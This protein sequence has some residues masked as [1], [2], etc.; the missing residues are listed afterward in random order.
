M[1]MA[2]RLY[3]NMELFASACETSCSNVVVTGALKILGTSAIIRSPPPYMTFN[4]LKRIWM[5]QQLDE[6]KDVGAGAGAGAGAGGAPPSHSIAKYMGIIATIV[7]HADEDCAIAPEPVPMLAPASAPAPEPAPAPATATP[8]A[9][10]DQWKSTWGTDQGGGGP[11]HPVLSNISGQRGGGITSDE[12]LCDGRLLRL[13][14][15]LPVEDG[16]RFVRDAVSDESIGPENVANPAPAKIQRT[17]LAFN[18]LKMVMDLTHDFL[19]V[20]PDIIQLLVLPPDSL[21]ETAAVRFARSN[22]R[23]GGLGCQSLSIF[24]PP[25]EK[26]GYRT[27]P[28]DGTQVQAAFGILWLYLYRRWLLGAKEGAYLSSGLKLLYGPPCELETYLRIIKCARADTLYPKAAGPIHKMR[29]RLRSILTGKAKT[30]LM[31]YVD[32]SFK[33]VEIQEKSKAVSLLF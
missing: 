27:A 6:A 31:T 3:E 1:M 4:L 8:R 11:R 21:T 18:G 32:N 10:R 28:G 26:E 20:F 25:P 15:G 2:Y 16:E 23:I 13:A 30:S 14:Y 5:Q 33:K 24:K 12:I 9:P 17:Y 19:S 29:A 22:P 7:C